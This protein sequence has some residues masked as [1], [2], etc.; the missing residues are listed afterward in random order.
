MFCLTD[1]AIDQESFSPLDE[2]VIQA[3]IP[4]IGHRLKFLKCFREF[5]SIIR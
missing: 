2:A 5:V 1:E 3:L 4:R